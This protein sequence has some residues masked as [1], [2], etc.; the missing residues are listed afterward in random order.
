MWFFAERMS[1]DCMVLLPR[2]PYPAPE[3]GYSW[4]QVLPGTWGFPSLEDLRPAA[5]GLMRFL[6]RWGSV[7]GVD[8]LRFDVAGF[9]QGAALTYVL[10]MLYPHRVE[11]MAALAGF[12]PAGA[13]TYLTAL[14][15][16]E[17]FI[18]HGRSDEIVPVERA[19]QAATLLR[20][21]GCQV[22]YCETE[23]G[24]KVSRECLRGM[25]LF[26]AGC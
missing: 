24:H 18:S 9:S 17:V 1:P 22:H 3:G 6:D 11:R 20:Q 7:S 25:E 10:G 16:K 8:V 2:A 12:L 4:R 19:Q 26:F 5:E 14:A 13:E 21:A 23:G 15:G